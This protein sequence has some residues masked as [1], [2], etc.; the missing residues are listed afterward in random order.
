MKLEMTVWDLS[1]NLSVK[2]NNELSQIDLLEKVKSLLDELTAFDEV[3]ISIQSV[4]PEDGEEDDEENGDEEA[5]V[6]DETEDNS[7]YRHAA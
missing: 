1:V 6:E 5:T 4:T 7:D 2:G 3:N